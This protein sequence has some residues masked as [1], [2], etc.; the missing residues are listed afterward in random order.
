MGSLLLDEGLVQG[1]VGEG[2]E[3]RRGSVGLGVGRRG[4]GAG[5]GRG[6]LGRKCVKHRRWNWDRRK[7]RTRCE[8]V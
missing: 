8:G 6:W 5:C 3:I 1:A 2:D 7:E 4:C